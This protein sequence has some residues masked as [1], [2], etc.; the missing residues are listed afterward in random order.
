MSGSLR[1]LIHTRSDLGFLVG[2]VSRCMEKPKES[3]LTTVKQILR[4]VKGTIN[5]GLKY[6][7][8]GDG[9]LVGYCDSSHGTDLD[10]QRSTSGMVYYYSALSSCE[11]EFIAATSAACQVVWLRNL[12]GDLFENISNTDYEAD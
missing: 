7:R 9:R 12:V 1:Y 10:D 8:G 3:H 2:A 5:Y 11:A 6:K 4:Y